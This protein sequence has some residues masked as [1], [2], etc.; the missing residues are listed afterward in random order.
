MS[1][2]S[3][4]QRDPTHHEATLSFIKSLQ[5]QLARADFAK[6]VTEQ[7]AKDRHTSAKAHVPNTT[8]SHDL[9]ASSH[10]GARITRLKPRS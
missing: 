7:P 10:L 9:Q 6:T 4:Q 2:V 5:E 1:F 8:K 3:A